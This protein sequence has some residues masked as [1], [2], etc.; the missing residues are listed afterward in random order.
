MRRKN[1]RRNTSFGSCERQWPQ[2]SRPSRNTSSCRWEGS[3][4]AAEWRRNVDSFRAD[5]TIMTSAIVGRG[6]ELALVEE[7]LAN[8]AEATG[9]ALAFTGSAGIGKSTVLRTARELALGQ[10]FEV[11]HV[12]GT[13]SESDLPYAALHALLVSDDRSALPDSLSTAIGLRATDAA[14][15]VIAVAAAL[16]RYLSTRA[17]HVPLLLVVD[18]MQWIDPSSAAVLSLTAGRLLADQVAMIFAIRTSPARRPLATSFTPDQG[19]SKEIELE[20]DLDQFATI[21]LT[22]HELKALTNSESTDLLHALGVPATRCPAVV[23]RS[24]G[25]PLLL[26]E[27]ARESSDNPDATEVLNEL[28]NEYLRRIR[29]LSGPAQQLPRA[30]GSGARVV[31]RWLATGFHRYARTGARGSGS[32]RGDPH[33]I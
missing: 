7:L 30:S 29:K 26:A 28:Q 11:R 24:H 9:G 32:G 13:P 5:Q 27:A 31:T 10:G 15:F 20:I 12:T 14:P 16:V 21:G 18:D 22:T 1:A 2:V 23:L 33:I 3:Q 17:E 4:F 6:I 8:A 25:V 19:P